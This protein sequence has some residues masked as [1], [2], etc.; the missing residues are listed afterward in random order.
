MSEDFVLRTSYEGQLAAEI[1]VLLFL[2]STTSREQPTLIPFF[3][4]RE[5]G[6]Q[7]LRPRGCIFGSYTK[8][9]AVKR[10]PRIGSAGSAPAACRRNF[11]V[12]VF[13]QHYEPRTV[14]YPWVLCAAA[15]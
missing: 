15:A 9:N 13:G 2:G 10:T 4:P 1:F 6:A 12:V 8:R 11:C 3:C 14:N 5:S 7:A